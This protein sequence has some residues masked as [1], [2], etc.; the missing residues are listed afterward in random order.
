MQRASVLEGITEERSEAV[1]LELLENRRHEINTEFAKNVDGFGRF[2][3]T[4]DVWQSKTRQ[5]Y[6]GV[7]A[8]FINDEFDIVYKVLALDALEKSYTEEDLHNAVLS[9]LKQFKALEMNKIDSVTR[10]NAT[11]NNKC[12]EFF[13]DAYERSTGSKFSGHE[14]RCYAHI[15]KLVVRA[16]E[17]Q[18]GANLITASSTGTNLLGRI[19]RLANMLAR[20]SGP[21]RLFHRIVNNQASASENKNFTKSV[22][23]KNDTRLNSTL[24]MLESFQRF[25]TCLVQTCTETSN[26]E[27]KDAFLTGAEWDIVDDVVHILKQFEMPTQNFQGQLYT[28][29]TEGFFH[30]RDLHCTLRE[31]IERF[32][33]RATENPSQA[34]LYS[35]FFF[36]SGFF[37]NIL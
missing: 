29:L 16:T 3:L 26:C 13:R 21:R 19:R 37:A 23:V 4:F 12:L 33:T 1:F 2:S 28:A 8:S 30:A 32:E 35:F 15:F 14:I 9:S 5:T 18:L 20:D 24:Y 31:E 36:F 10:D 22:F 34:S 6:L 25:K 27:F 7:V 11:I 17:A